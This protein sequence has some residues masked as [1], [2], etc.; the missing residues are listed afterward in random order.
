MKRIA[1]FGLTFVLAGLIA[2]PAHA[3]YMQ[4]Q[5]AGIT[6][7][8][9]YSQLTDDWTASSDFEWGFIGGGFFEWQYH[10]NLSGQLEI[11]Y[12][13]RGGSGT[14]TGVPADTFDIKLAYLAFPVT[15]NAMIPVSQTIDLRGTVGFSFALSLS[16]KAG[17]DGGDRE[18]CGST[19]PGLE[20]ESI[21]WAFPLGAGIGFK[22]GK[23]KVELDARYHLGL[24]NVLKTAIVKNRSWEFMVRL[25]QAF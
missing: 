12:A 18:S 4:T 24:S 2:A 13:Q 9:T 1:T 5:R 15:L 3:Q 10:P 25:G 20:K 19:F 6:L 23:N 14:R 11:N 7:G 17:I 16:C 8:G 21:E 22:F